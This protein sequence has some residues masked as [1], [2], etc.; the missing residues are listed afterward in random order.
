[1]QNSII[2]LTYFWIWFR[3][4]WRYEDCGE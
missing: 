2:N 4:Y 3:I 1:M